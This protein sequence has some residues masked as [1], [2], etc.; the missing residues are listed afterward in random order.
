MSGRNRINVK[1]VNSAQPISNRQIV[2]RTRFLSHM[3]IVLSGYTFE[4]NAAATNL[5]KEMISTS[6]KRIV[7]KRMEGSLSCYWFKLS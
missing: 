2:K 4:P 5:T 1:T 7:S 3:T 6:R